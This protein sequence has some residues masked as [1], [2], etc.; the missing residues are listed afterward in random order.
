MTPGGRLGRC[1]NLAGTWHWSALPRHG[2]RRL[3]VDLDVNREVHFF[4][5]RQRRNRDRL[6][7]RLGDDLELTRGNPR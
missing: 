2:T 7:L 5:W 3:D 1:R 6:R 4:R